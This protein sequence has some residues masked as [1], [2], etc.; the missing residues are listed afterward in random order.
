[1][2]D[3]HTRP[4]PLL[5]NALDSWSVFPHLS[6][7]S[8][9][10]CKSPPTSFLSPPAPTSPIPIHPIHL[11]SRF[12]PLS[13]SLSASL[14]PFSPLL[15]PLT[16]LQCFNVTF[17]KFVKNWRRTDPTSDSESARDQILHCVFDKSSEERRPQ[18]LLGYGFSV[19]ER[20]ARGADLRSIP[21]SSPPESHVSVRLN[22]RG[23]YRYTD[24][25][26]YLYSHLEKQH[27]LDC[28]FGSGKSQE[29]FFV[30]WVC[31]A[32]CGHCLLLVELLLFVLI[33]LRNCTEFR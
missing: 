33:T 32:S 21:S 4:D 25:P 31:F 29:S 22:P 10:R 1:M 16:D 18:C 8:L 2:C 13:S 24:R 20:K 23:F 28:S 26:K 11:P 9:K 7:G 15:F 27:R 30:K 3:Q 19:F 17:L 5:A 6:S 14:T 12:H